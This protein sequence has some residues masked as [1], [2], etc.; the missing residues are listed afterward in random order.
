MTNDYTIQQYYI[1]YYGRPADPS[2]LAYWV[3][4][5][6]NGMSIESLAGYFGAPTAGSEFVAIYGY[7]PTPEEFF[8]SAY[9]NIYNR[10]PDAEGLAWWL[11]KYNELLE[12]GMNPIDVRAKIVIWMVDD[13]Q[14]KAEWDKAVFLNKMDL[15]METTSLAYNLNSQE[16]I[17]LL[18]NKV[19]YDYFPDPDIGS[20]DVLDAAHRALYEDYTHILAEGS[21]QTF[22]LIEVGTRPDIADGTD[23]GSDSSTGGTPQVVYWGYNMNDGGIPVSDLLSFVT[24]ITGLDL[25]ELGL[26]DDD[27]VGPFDNVTSLTLAPS[28]N[29]SLT[30]GNENIDNPALD[31][32]Q[33][34]GVPEDYGFSALT[35]NFSDG[36]SKSAEVE[37][38]EQYFNFLNN[39]LFYTDPDT[40]VLKSRLYMGDPDGT[41]GTGTGDTDS[42]LTPIILTPTQNNGGTFEE[43][44]TTAGDDTIVTGRLELLHGAYIDAGGGYNTLEVDAKGVFAQ[45]LELLNIQE[46]R[47][48]NLPNVYTTTDINN[49]NYPTVTDTALAGAL[50]NSIL[51]LSRATSIEKLV[52]TEGSFEGFEYR[53]VPGTL[54]IAGIRNGAPATLDGG[55][56]QNVTLHYSDVSAANGINLVFRNLSMGDELNDLTDPVLN[57]AHNAET[58]NIESTG[59]DNFLHKADLG[60]MLRT[61]NITGNAHLFIKGDLN[62]SFHDDTPVFID[63]SGNTGGVD[64]TLTGLGDEITFTGTAEANDH[65]TA[66]NNA[67]VVTI[68]GGNG[69]NEFSVDNANIVNITAGDGDNEISAEGSKAVTITAGSGDN[70]I[71][72]DGAETATVTTG[73]GNNSLSAINTKTVAITT[74]DGNDTIAASAE[75]I[76]INSAAG[77]DVVSIA[78]IAGGLSTAA[79]AGL[80]LMLILNDSGSMS[81]ER[82]TALK[83]GLN[84]LFDNLLANGIDTAAITV[85]FAGSAT[86]GSWGSIEAARTAVNAMTANGSDTNYDAAITAAMTAWDTTGKINGA[87]NVS[88]FVS[89]ATVPLDATI[90][91]NWETFVSE[92]GISSMAVGVDVSNTLGLDGVAY[93]GSN[94][95]DMDPILTDADGLANVLDNLTESLVANS[96]RQALVTIDLGAGNNTLH[97]GDA[98]QMA[99]GLVALEGSSITG[100]NITLVVNANADLRAASLSGISNVVL[101]NGDVGSADRTVDNGMLTLTASQFVDIGAAN[102]SVEGSIFHTRGLIKLIVEDDI[103]LTDIGAD[104]LPRN[105]DLLIEINDGATLTMT[106]EQLHKWVMPQGLTLADDGNTDEA[107]GN[108]VIT[109]GGLDFDPFN[110]SDTIKTNI[111][112][113]IYYGGSLSD[114]FKV[115][116]D[117]YNVTVN[118]TLNGFDRPADM[119]AEVVITFDSGI[120]LDAITQGAFSTWH[121]NLEITGER[122]IQFTGTAQ[123]GM[124]KGVPTNPFTIDFSQLE[125]N[126][127]DFTV[128]NFELLAQGG[129]IYGNADKGYASEVHIHIADDDATDGV[130]F[131]EDDAS[132]LVSRGVSKYVVTQIDGPTANGSIGKTATIKLC[133]SAQDIEVFALRGNYN[134]ILKLEDAAWGLVFELQGGS[135]AKADGPTGTANVGILDANFEWEGASAVV[136][137]VH[138]VAGDARP[139]KAS[140]IEIDNADSI[141][142]NSNAA[143]AI[144]DH[145]IGNDAASL[146]F[147]SAA[148]SISVTDAINLEDSNGVETDGVALSSI[149]ASAV[150]GDFTA[151]LTG[152]A[153]GAGFDFVASAGTTTLTLDDVKA[154]FHSSFS[155]EDAATFNLVIA[156]DSIVDLA[157]ATLT[158]VDSVALDDGATL[159]LSLTQI[160]AIGAANI[161]M[162][163]PGETGT[164]NIE[165]MT[166]ALFDVN[167]LGDGVSLGTVTMAEGSYTLDPATDLTGATLVVPAGS[168]LTLTADQYMALVAL[169]GA[170]A[171]A[172]IHITDLTQAHIDAGFSL[173]DVSNA[174]GTVTLAES[175]NLAEN[176]NLNGFAVIMGDDMELGI[177]TPE[178]ADGL[179][180]TGGANSILK[181]L[182]S[183]LG[184]DDS[185]D[186]SGYNVSEVQFLPSLVAGQNVDAVFANLPESVVKSVYQS[187]IDMVDQTVTVQ[188][189]VTVPGFMAFSLA[190]T[191]VELQDFTLNLEGGSQV[192]GAINLGFTAARDEVATYLDSVTIN[193][194]GTAENLQTAKTANIITGALTSQGDT[195][196][197]DNELLNVTINAE[198][199]L[200]MGGIVFESMRA[201]DATAT[202]VVNGTAAVNAGA[203]DTTD[204][205]VDGLSVVNNG[206]GTLT[207]GIDADNIDATDALSFTGTGPIVLSITGEVD[208]SDDDL[209]AVTGIVLET[210]A[211]ALTLTMEQ[212]DAIGAANFAAA[213][214]AT[215]ANLNLIGLN[216]QPFAVANYSDDI[217]VDVVT[218][219]ALPVVTLNPATD[220]TDIGSLVVPEGTVLNLTAAQFQ[221]LDGGGTITG[222]GGTT[223]FTVNI[224]DL[225]QAD[226]AG[227]FD[228]SGITADTLTLT[229]AEDVTLGA[230]DD[231]HTA[232][233]D[234]GGFIFTLPEVSMADGLNITGTVYSVLN[235]TDLD[236]DSDPSDYIDASG[237]AVEEL[238]MTARLVAG[239]NVDQIFRGLSADILKVIVDDYGY[240]D[241]TTQVATILGGSFVED[242]VAFIK[243]EPEIEIR[244]FT[245]NLEGGVLLDGDVNLSTVEFDDLI[246]TY[247]QTVT[248][249]S[250]AG[251]AN[252][253]NGET[254]NV[255]SGNLTSESFTSP[256]YIPNNLLDVTINAE[257]VL[258]LGGIVFESV[259]VSDFDDGIT[260]NDV[261]DAVAVLTI[262]GTADVDVGTLDTSDTDVDGLNVVNNGTGTLSAIVNAANIDADDALSFTGTGDIALTVVGAVNLS[263]DVTTAVSQVT[264]AEEAALTLSFAQMTAIGAAN[265][266]S[267]DTDDVVDETLTLVD[268]DGSAFDFSTLSDELLVHL[269]MA[270]GDIT[271]DPAVDLSG[272]DSITVPEGGSLTLTAA[273]FQQLDN[274]G[275]IVGIDADGN[276]TTD[277]T[278]NITDLTQADIDAGFDLSNVTADSIAVTAAEDLVFEAATDLNGASIEIGSFSLGLATHA[279]A[280][281]LVVT[282]DANSVV[283]FL[284]DIDYAING[285]IE[286]GGYD[287]GTLRAIA[288]TV[289][290]EDVE[291]IIDNLA[292]SIALNLYETPEEVGYVSGIHRIVNIEDGVAVPGNL[293][294][295][296]QDGDREMRT[297]T[298]NFEGDANDGR[299]EL[300]DQDGNLEG[301]IIAG[302]L[303]LDRTLETSPLIAVKLQKL[304]LNSFGAGNS[305]SITGS[306][307]PLDSD[308]AGPNRDNN[309]LDVEINATSDFT[310]GG[311]IIFSSTDDDDATATLTVTGA[312]DVSVEQ[313]DVS[314]TDVDA[315]AVNNTGTGTLTITGASPAIVGPV[316]SVTFAGTGDIVLGTIAEGITDGTI[317][318]IDAS[319][320]SG[321]LTMDLVNDVDDADFTFTSG[322][323]V[324]TM[325]FTDDDLDS[326]GTDGNPGTADDTA[327]WTLDFTNAA[328]GSELHLSGDLATNAEDGSTFNVLAGANTTIYIDSNYDISHLNASLP[329]GATIVVADDVTLTLT[330]AQANGLTIIAGPD[331]GGAGFNGAVQIVELG[332]YPDTNSNG[333]N[334]DAAELIDYDFS[335]ITAPANATLFD[336]DVT[337]SAG[338][339]LGTVSIVLDD[340][341]DNRLTSLVGQTIRFSTE[342]QAARVITVDEVDTDPDDNDSSTNVIWLFDTITGPVDTDGYDGDIGRVW[343]SEDLVNS[344]GGDVEGMFTTLQTQILRVDF[345]DVTELNAL[346]ASQA[347]D[348][349]F[350]VAAFSTLNDLTFSDVGL[351]PEEHLDTLTIMM[352]GSVTIGDI[353]VDDVVNPGSDPDSVVFN[354]LTI[355][356][357]RA[358]RTGDLLAPEGF[359]NNNDGVIQAGEHAQ[360]ANTNVVGDIFV[361]ANNGIDLT[362]VTLDTG[363]VTVIG[364]GSA[365][366]GANLTVGTIT[367]ETDTAGS[368]ATLTLMGANKITSA[369]VDTSDA[370]ITTYVEDVSGFTGVLD[371]I[372]NLNSTE[373]FTLDDT[374]S[375]GVATLNYDE[376][377]GDE[378]SVVDFSDSDDIINILF[379][380]IDSNDDGTDDA[381]TFT[382]GTG[383]NTVV[384]QQ[385]GAK[386]P[387][388]E[389][390]STWNFDMSTAAP[391][392]SLT[393]GAGTALANG[394]NLNVELTDGVPLI[395]DD[396][397]DLTGVNLT[398]TG[399]V[400]EVTAGSSLTITVDQLVDLYNGG[401]DSVEIVGLGTLVVVDGATDGTDLPQATFG[402]ARTANL[403]LSG[404]TIDGTD[405]TGMLEIALNTAGSASG[406][407]E[408]AT[409]TITPDMTDDGDEE[410]TVTYSLDGG[411]TDTTQVVNLSGVD[412]TDADA[413]ATAIAAAAFGG[414]FTSVEAHGNTVY[415]VGALGEDIQVSAAVTA[416]TTDSLS[417][418]ESD[419]GSSVLDGIAVIG[420]D[421]DD[422]I[423]GTD[424]D[425][426]FTMGAGDDVIEGG[427]G[428][429]TFNVDEG[430]DTILDLTSEEDD[431]NPL[432][433]EENDVLVVSSGATATTLNDGGTPAD[434]LDDDGYVVGDFYA[435]A[436]TT[437]AGTAIIA[438]D[439]DTDQTID[440]S[441]ASGPN[442]YTIIGGNDALAPAAGNDILIGSAFADT[443]NGGNWIQEDEDTVDVLTGNGGSDRFEFNILSQNATLTA[444]TTTAAID[445]ELITFTFDDT[446]EGTETITVN[447]TVNSAPGVA[448]IDLTGV[449]VTNLTAITNAAIAALD[450]KAG[451]SAAAGANP[452]EVVISGDNSAAVTIGVITVND[453][454]EG[455]ALTAVASDGTD[456]AQ[457]TTVTV[458]GTASPGDQYNLLVNY[459]NGG[460]TTGAHTAVGAD[461]AIQV[462][463]GL[464]ALVNETVVTANNAGGT[465][466]VITLT[467]QSLAD[468]DTNGGFTVQQDNNLAF[469]G[470]G[471]GDAG[472]DD[473]T[474]AD[475]I[476]D[477]TAGVDT[478]SFG[479]AAGVAGGNY[480]EAAAV[481]DYATALTNADAA[482]N[483]TIQY[484]LT[485]ATDLDGTATTGLVEGQEGAGLLFFDANLD[486]NTDGVVLLLGINSGNFGADSIVA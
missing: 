410:M 299:T 111:G 91:S 402:V 279:Q 24:S 441:L 272:V 116:G 350:E 245:L 460:G 333:N 253:I 288:L 300:E 197:L 62:A 393:I 89:D 271:L 270:A 461:T 390:G 120:G 40:G 135:T 486:G 292:N 10:A 145:V 31:D 16:D 433:D 94:N 8:V 458:S 79:A 382:A 412:V 114:D 229:L 1:A 27:G 432:T 366:Q 61:L 11:G 211:T 228:L 212:A 485:S 25:A 103:S 71:D 83:Q 49:S 54:T 418:A 257:E 98:D 214:G 260:A 274:E 166:D 131:D 374:N 45:P 151:T 243:T 76:A 323:G 137:L 316:E 357:Y 87:T 163:H 464:A 188:P 297:L 436:A 336:D 365:G 259:T 415:F 476:T 364:N 241:G 430:T 2:G 95:R 330:A 168:E 39:L 34:V 285:E 217:D 118:S 419:A 294:F 219:A 453:G 421:E 12:Q 224:T 423:T 314:D 479:L 321:N 447:Y 43:G 246:P 139:I 282:G 305:N 361:G 149:D 372:Y 473:Y 255:I 341:A 347:V 104:S 400:I 26:I 286:A 152:D 32:G 192:T 443:I 342:E 466:A 265:I 154:G 35:I 345:A 362:D 72:V 233:I 60:G 465:T 445:R 296:G 77:N 276:P 182:F 417:A 189:G 264:I 404:I 258:T 324:T 235:F 426:T 65:F 125:A 222:V 159:T 331:T 162:T 360:P 67:D 459:N 155:A 221:Q 238:H 81:G 435:T 99:Q 194:A 249:N 463:T 160:E 318:E 171:T 196:E 256:D 176:T 340:L 455:D 161:G 84:G 18:I 429:D 75:T 427:D 332:D 295:N 191:G 153:Q 142:V 127:I 338:S 28:V 280:D 55:F 156:E 395:I 389:A 403:D 236:V 41:T 203:L 394:S 398:V 6:E 407:P 378:L 198:Q 337:I 20:Q 471:A 30:E 301:S 157:G 291:L 327:G 373:A 278:V 416:G 14:G 329:V 48:E 3:E 57:V 165:G 454:D 293:I 33:S 59:A 275:T 239:E 262:N 15:A 431:G 273:Q 85:I 377:Y 307:S 193:S 101:D 263:D 177:A 386:I 124:D 322:T 283:S 266:L 208:L 313:L 130:G 334:D 201:E 346:L 143:D 303:I 92:R 147:A 401:T 107:A 414:A 298:I 484:Y 186:A 80:N 381:F 356:S 434:P 232:D 132:S 52:I 174:T 462:A 123:L 310:I 261:D 369:G 319:G 483:G 399:G 5:I 105:I 467:H 420:S 210:A 21:D 106:A 240:V 204:T 140:G 376:V 202:L 117:W 74:G 227:G 437:N 439:N 353:A 234:I 4:Q 179:E 141:T 200:E 469:A 51:D 42:S 119:P 409:L 110:T 19:R 68:I 164:L 477:F 422:D 146:V 335:N 96:G 368:T 183:S 66:D 82:I 290:G 425:D 344:E 181:M 195:N 440:L 349:I 302:N 112:G 206:T 133:D 205:D 438:G 90:Q 348:R 289:A 9:Q 317:S 109:G 167:A 248:I 53:D 474:L 173:T 242:S 448:L 326:T 93:D 385:V 97:L 457:V 63:A 150:A 230:G 213:A 306:I 451:I 470:S 308:A 312:A 472:A 185:L 175:L 287:I 126:V 250:N 383:V 73:D 444:A 355:E 136:D 169:D 475:V 446:D 277:F 468:V 44:Y 384:V 23:S 108:V 129:G 144:I 223:N 281:D 209:A 218:I 315:L 226:V 379:S 102:F 482:F 251:T 352:G 254:A 392:S 199:A 363:A 38:G 247:L 138:S 187:V 320:L 449:D 231:L 370:D 375:A 478:I 413:I 56:T 411:A 122:D 220:L 480:A 86:A 13:I 371:P 311:A 367:F 78:G 380:D 29:A 424:L 391:G 69:D 268:Y 388:L 387:T 358:V 172:T 190:D 267:G 70:A 304:T 22:T 359:T 178:Q 252:V 216:D 207:V 134:D 244:D 450:V 325:T 170:A 354:G 284:F 428:D 237:F 406:A 408:V 184:S 481:A 225:M 343:F 128:D 36:T 456:V 309:L 115:D 47:V 397:V 100:E 339:D 7:E 113:N 17:S 158:G 37:L 215:G 46:V 452:G 64:L 351:D 442:G 269:V 396:S 180:V 121:T 405:G 50:A 328:A 88:L 148:N 58:L